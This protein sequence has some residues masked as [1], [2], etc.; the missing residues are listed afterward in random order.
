MGVGQ[1]S[2]YCTERVL[3]RD[4]PWCSPGKTVLLVGQVAVM[5]GG[6]G[7]GRA[8]MRSRAR[9][10]QAWASICINNTIVGWV[11]ENF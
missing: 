5:K 11:F 2:G 7:E 8:D 4:G 6:D 10:N 9:P 3:E 1:L